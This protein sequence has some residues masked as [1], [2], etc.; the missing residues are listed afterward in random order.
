MENI[1]AVKLKK[2]KVEIKYENENDERDI[3]VQ[4]TETPHPE[5]HEA[6]EA[7]NSFLVRMFHIEQKARYRV[8]ASGVVISRT[9]NT[10]LI[11]GTFLMESQ[12][13]VALNSG[14]IDIVSEDEVYGFEEDLAKFVDEIR[15]EAKEF[16]NGKTA[17]GRLFGNDGEPAREAQER[18]DVDP[19]EVFREAETDD[20]AETV[21]NQ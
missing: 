6:I 20:E 2:T 16:L 19:G 13:K 12:K 8:Q 18:S 15:E 4:S 11:T 3:T 7:L 10:V 1:L 14:N 17:Q 5:L 21:N 9:G